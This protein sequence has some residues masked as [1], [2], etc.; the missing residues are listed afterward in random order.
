MLTVDILTLFPE[1]FDSILAHSI[2]KR[3]IQAK[4]VKVNIHNIRDYALDKHKV[5]DDRPY[6]GGPGMLMKPEP[7]DRLAKKLYPKGVTKT[8]AFIYPSAQGRPFNQ[9]DAQRLAKKRRITILCGHYEGVDDRVLQR[10]VTEEICVTDCV[11]TGGEIPAMLILD[12]VMRLLPG[13]LGNEASKSCESFNDNLLEYPHYTRP[14]VF[15]GAAV[16]PVLL[17]GNHKA[18]DEWR[19]KQAVQRTAKRRPDLYEKRKDLK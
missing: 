17:T 5:C 3:A 16:P 6:G 7:I 19:L 14:A 10:W 11:L 18:I 1:A 9:K 2:L 13:V 12:G 8:S 4:K 15:R